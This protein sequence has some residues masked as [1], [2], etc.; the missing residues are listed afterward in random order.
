MNDDDKLREDSVDDS[1]EAQD[2]PRIDSEDGRTLHRRVERRRKTRT[3]AREPKLTTRVDFQVD[4]LSSRSSGGYYTRS[5]NSITINH[6]EGDEDF[7]D[8]SQSDA[9]LIH[10]QKHRDNHRYGMFAYAVSV[11]QAYKLCMHNEISA[12]MATLI[13]LRDEYLKTKDL[14]VFD[15]DFGRFSFYANAIKNGVI[16]PFSDSKEDFDKEMALIVNGTRD[17]WVRTFAEG[18]SSAHVKNAMVYG[19][20]DG[21]HAEFYDENYDRAMKIAYNIGGVDFTQY[22]GILGDVKVPF[23]V[24]DEVLTGDRLIEVRSL[25]KYDGSMSL[26]QY[27]KLLQH[28]DV[29]PFMSI[30]RE[31]I[32]IDE[33]KTKNDL[34]NLE[35]K[36]VDSILGA[37]DR[38]HYMYD[39]GFYDGEMKHSETHYDFIDKIIIDIAKD[40]ERRGEKLPKDNDEAYNE[41]IDKLYNVTLSLDPEYSYTRI[42]NIREVL[43]PNDEVPMTELPKE[44]QEIQEK[45]EN[46]PLLSRCVVALNYQNNGKS[47]NPVRSVKEEPEYR[48]WSESSRVSDVQYAELLNLRAQVIEEPTDKPDELS[49]RVSLGDEENINGCPDEI[50]GRRPREDRINSE[51]RMQRDALARPQVMERGIQNDRVLR[52]NEAVARRETSIIDREALRE[53]MQSAAREKAQMIKVIEEVNQVNGVR[54]ALDVTKTVDVLYD[55]FGDNAYEVLTEAVYKPFKFAQ[56]VGDSSI[57]TSHDVVMSLCNTDETKAREVASVVLNGRDR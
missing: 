42:I 44:A 52:F 20:K 18:Y 7:N 5:R 49:G 30:L 17:M 41:A 50:S 32:V 38:E 16:D 34:D 48:E 12:N 23:T 39:R 2:S 51:I 45:L 6:V 19:E 8:W 14:S 13:Y 53:D 25:P 35:A 11:E 26:L 33:N 29:T 4:T 43:N 54:Y 36:D 27:Q 40:Y 3:N 21:K 55:K 47:N 46:M 24:V 28:A 1:I 10:E 9:V 22:I 31:P 37:D 15:Y 56:D 57:R